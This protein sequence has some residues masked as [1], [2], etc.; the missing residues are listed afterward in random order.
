MTSQVSGTSEIS[1]DGNDDDVDDDD[2]VIDD[3]APLSFGDDQ[4][5][6]IPFTADESTIGEQDQSTTVSQHARGLPTNQFQDKSTSVHFASP[7]AT[8]Q[9]Q[10]QALNLEGHLQTTKNLFGRFTNALKFGSSTPAAAPTAKL[11][12]ATRSRPRDAPAD[13]NAR[14]MRELRAAQHAAQAAQATR[15]AQAAQATRDAR[16]AQA[17]QATRDAQVAQAQADQVAQALAAQLQAAQAQAAQAHAAQ[18]QA[19]QAAQAVHAAQA[20]HAARAAEAAHVAQTSR[21][22][23]RNAH[24]EDPPAHDS[25]EPLDATNFGVDPDAT[26]DPSVAHGVTHDYG[27]ATTDNTTLP[28]APVPY[29]VP[30]FPTRSTYV[31]TS[32]DGV[33]DPSVSASMPAPY[34]QPAPGFV[35]GSAP[36]P[37][38]T[39]PTPADAS[40]PATATAPVPQPAAYSMWGWP[41]GRGGRN[42]APATSAAAAPPP[43]P[44]GLPGAP[45][46]E[47]VPPPGGSAPPPDGFAPPPGAPVPLPSGPAPLPGGFAPSP[48][49]PPVATSTGPIPDLDGCDWRMHRVDP[50]HIDSYMVRDVPHGIN[51]LRPWRYPRPET[52]TTRNFAVRFRAQFSSKTDY[53]HSIALPRLGNEHYTVKSFL[54]TFPKLPKNASK[55]QICDFL[56]RVCRHGTGFAVYVP[57]FA[58]MTHANHTGLWYPDLPSHCHIHW[59]FYDQVLHQALSGSP[60]CLYDTDSTKHL[61]AEFSGYQILWLLA[62]IAGHPGVSISVMQPSMPRQKRDMS[63]HDYMQEWSHFLHLEHCRGI[64]YSDVY[65]VETWLERL[66]PTFNDTVK[67]LILG[68][69]RDCSRNEP[70]PI[71]FSPEHLLTYVCSRATSIGIT[72]LTPLSSP[73]TLST[74][75]RSNSTNTSS[76]TTRQLEVQFQDVRLLDHE[77][78]DDI[79]ASVCSLMAASS[80]RSCDICQDTNHMVASCP[81]LHRIIADPD[82][83]RRLLSAIDRGRTSRGG[84]NSSTPSS[85]PSRP[86]SRARTPPT[87]NRSTAVRQ[88]STHD[89]DD[90]DEDV[91]IRQLTDDEDDDS[92][93]AGSG[94]ADFP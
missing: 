90:T 64:A 24:L 65:F 15:E 8:I 40:Q 92:R 7:I 88:L 25:A 49:P 22:S 62:N 58:T 67:P 66:H 5:R 50:R 9:T 51:T 78:P 77:L 2:G 82:K 39:Q 35:F 70:V 94:S 28:A 76:A 83:V 55:A 89:D 86:N 4:S 59:E 87:N 32:A 53:L 69:L 18:A 81:V 41:F 93:S 45:S 75:R 85:T 72:T 34:G 60:A 14:A 74:S 3:D 16:A 68:L 17:A 79:Y 61:V 91:S 44:G 54:H 19:A 33:A 23:T 46:G 43:P 13:D 27:T 56:H 57:P 31:A 1:E 71:H 63:F 80:S 47:A 48:P 20:A 12:P 21:T 10:A 37:A 38:A 42:P 84:S 6:P 11:R 36:F 29:A 73:T 26:H 30:P 52:G